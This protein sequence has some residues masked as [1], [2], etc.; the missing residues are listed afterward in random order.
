MEIV[1][2]TLSVS[3]GV[4]YASNET[5]SDVRVNIY[6]HSC[7]PNNPLL[8]NVRVDVDA[9]GTVFRLNSLVFQEN[10]EAREWDERDRR[11]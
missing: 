9:S 4:N 5:E 6:S 1:I 10:V 11:I 7:T 2:L 8:C 3:L